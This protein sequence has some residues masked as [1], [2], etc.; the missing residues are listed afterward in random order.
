MKSPTF[1]G[2]MVI[3]ISDFI[4]LSGTP[5]PGLFQAYFDT[6]RPLLTQSPMA[7]LEITDDRSMPALAPGLFALQIVRHV[8]EIGCRLLPLPTNVKREKEKST[9]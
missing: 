1:M 8:S 9:K 4:G 3:R 5:E 7:D 6:S 2:E